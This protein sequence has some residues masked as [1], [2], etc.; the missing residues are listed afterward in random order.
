MGAA[1]CL[2]VAGTLAMT[3]VSG[4]IAFNGWPGLGVQD[5]GE[6]AALVAEVRTGTGAIVTAAPLRLRPPAPAPR[7]TPSRARRPAVVTSSRSGAQRAA[8]PTRGGPS[9]T[10][11]RPRP[12]KP[13]VKNP[14]PEVPEVPAAAPAPGE[15]VRDLGK[16]LDTTVD[17]TGKV[18][19]ELVT[20]TAPVLGPVVQNT[21]DVVGNLLG[22]VVGVVGTI[23]DGLGQPPAG[24]P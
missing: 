20:P 2:L 7:V 15:P 19:A 11:A 24:T 8:A 23:V 12:P 9:D 4:L 13:V 22:Q 3:L 16:A 17:S 1:T 14:A 18:V 10:G 6:Q 5:V 21:T